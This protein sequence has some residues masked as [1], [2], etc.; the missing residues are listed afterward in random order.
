M[1]VDLFNLPVVKKL[2]FHFCE[3]EESAEITKAFSEYRYDSKILMFTNEMTKEI[4][5]EE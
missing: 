1:I 4:Y 5:E 3:D 2:I